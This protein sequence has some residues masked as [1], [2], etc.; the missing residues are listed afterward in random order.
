MAANTDHLTILTGASRG[1]GLSMAGQLLDAGH[2]LLCISRKTNDAL[3]AH[4]QAKGRSLE[5]WPHDLSRGDVVAA[6]LETWLAARSSAGLAGVT[7]IN[8]AGVIPAIAPVGEIAAADLAQ[9]LRVGLE[10]PML[11]TG[12]FLR[13]TATWPC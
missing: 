10:A 8:N 12:A 6:K 5:Q 11:L 4:A 3:A 9:A 2:Q 1:M 13:A 7:L